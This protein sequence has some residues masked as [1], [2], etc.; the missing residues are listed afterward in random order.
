MQSAGNQRHKSSLVGSSETIRATTFHSPV[1]SEGQK[2]KF[3]EWLAGLIDANGSLLV[4]KKGYIS[5]EI[6][7]PIEDLRTLRYIQNFIGGSIKLR[8]GVKAYRYRLH[9]K[10]AIINLINGINGHI[11]HSSRIIQLHRICQILN[12]SVLF[13]SILYKESKWFAGFFDGDGTITMNIKNNIPQLNIRVTNKKLEDIKYYQ[14]FFGGSIYFDNSNYGCYIW[15]IQNRE[16][17]I[18]CKEYF[19]K[20]CRSNKSRRF[21]LIDH[22]FYLKDL[23]AYKED[24]I[25]KKVWRTF[26]ENWNSK[27]E[28]IVQPNLLGASRSDIY[29]S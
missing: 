3:F 26:L 11:R 13:P 10:E 29:A 7:M 15:S 25:H 9:N 19:K 2:E 8:S 27:V 1:R 14:T 4:N 28:N 17:V 20:E 22:F 12:I 16:D 21:F 6:T 24:S 18:K 23:K 5:L